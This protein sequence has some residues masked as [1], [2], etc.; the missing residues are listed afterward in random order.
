MVTDHCNASFFALVDL[1][2]LIFE[3]VVLFAELCA[4]VILPYYL[5]NFNRLSWLILL[6]N[7]I[8]LFNVAFGL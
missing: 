5:Y 1:K 2:K 8:V 4:R 6:A 7:A 3:M